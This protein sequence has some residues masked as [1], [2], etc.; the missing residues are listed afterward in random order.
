MKRVNWS[1]LMM[2]LSVTTPMPAAG[3]RSPSVTLS[4]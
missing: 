2:S 4:M 1:S 3:S